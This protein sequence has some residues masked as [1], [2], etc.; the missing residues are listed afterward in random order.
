L[1][2]AAV[3]CFLNKPGSFQSLVQHF[4]SCFMQRYNLIWRLFFVIGL[5]GIAVQQIYFKS[6][7]PIIVPGWP[8]WILDSVFLVW[9]VSLALIIAAIA[10]LAGFRKAALW[11]GFLFLVFVVLL[12]LPELF[13][14]HTYSVGGWSSALKL[15]ALSRSALIVARSLPNPGGRRR[16]EG[17]PDRLV[18]AGPF[19]FAIMMVVFGIDHFVY[20]G[21]VSS[22]VPSWIPGS[23]FWTYFCGIALFLAGLAIILQVRVRLVA[24]LLGLMIFIWVFVL[25]IPRAIANPDSGGIGNEW[26][27]V[28]EAFAFS[29]I[30]FM[31]AG[32]AERKRVYQS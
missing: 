23:L 20:P 9:V 28:F 11:L 19:F 22:L 21:F 7:R 25:H 32:Q 17:F 13:R 10:I 27:S 5:I 15:L 4:Q 6:F 14:S 31:L 29:G 26:T 30:A 24:L 1:K 18:P 3:E 16:D 12:H 2:E 8:S